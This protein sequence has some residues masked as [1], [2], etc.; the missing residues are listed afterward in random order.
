MCQGHN[1][2][3]GHLFLHS[4]VAWKLWSGSVL[5]QWRLCFRSDIWVLGGARMRKFFGNVWCLVCCGEFGVR[6]SR[7]LW[8]QALSFVF[9]L[10]FGGENFI[11]CLSQAFSFRCFSWSAHCWSL[12]KLGGSSSLV[13]FIA[14]SLLLPFLIFELF[15]QMACSLFCFPSLIK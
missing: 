8:E 13:F 9:F 15:R 12:E 2:T 6:N 11:V 5:I 3:H 14:Y 7:I 4:P 1:E 10:C